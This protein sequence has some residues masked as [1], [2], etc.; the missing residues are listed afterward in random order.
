MEF[1][2]VKQEGRLCEQGFA[3]GILRAGRNVLWTCEHE[4]ASRHGAIQCAYHAEY[5]ARTA[6]LLPDIPQRKWDDPATWPES[7]R[8]L[9]AR[10]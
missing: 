6:G 9:Q 10:G 3:R 5:Q 4:H 7:W 1:V 8:R 2:G